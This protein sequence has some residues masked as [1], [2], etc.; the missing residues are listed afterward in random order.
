[1]DFH[2]PTETPHLRYICVTQHPITLEG[3]TDIDNTTRFSLKPFCGVIRELG[4][5]L[6]MCNSYAYRNTCTAQH[7]TTNVTPERIKVRDPRQISKGLVDVKERCQPMD[8]SETRADS[9]FP[10]NTPWPWL[11]TYEVLSESNLSIPKS[12]VDCG[13]HRFWPS[14]IIHAR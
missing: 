1:M 4:Q 11:S 9:S 14:G 3:I 2:T 5:R 13:Q 7:L 6:R 10:L 8:M 12:A